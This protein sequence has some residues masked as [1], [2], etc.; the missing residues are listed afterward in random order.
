LTEIL[1]P[2]ILFIILADLSMAND[3]RIGVLINL[4]KSGSGAKDATDDLK[5]LDQ[6]AK[7]LSGGLAGL[8]D[9]AGI[10]GFAALGAAAGGVVFE[11]GKAAATAGDMRVVFDSMAKDAGESGEAMLNAMRTASAGMV[12]DAALVEA[13]NRAML[14]GV[15]DSSAEMTQLL[16]IA[17]V[18]GQAMGLS[19][20]EAFGDVVTGIG[21]LSPMILDNLGIAI[22]LQDTYDAYA[23]SLGR[24]SESLSDAEKKQALLN[25]VIANTAPLIASSVGAGQDQMASFE[26]LATS[27]SNAK[28]AFGELALTAGLPGVLQGASDEIEGL[29][30]KIRDLVISVGLLKEGKFEELFAFETGNLEAFA[31]DKMQGIGEQLAAQAEELRKAQANFAVEGDPEAQISALVKMEDAIAALGQEYN[32]LATKA[33]EPL[34]DLNLLQQGVVTAE[35]VTD[36]LNGLSEAEQRA[37]QEQEGWNALLSEAPGVVRQWAIELQGAGV[38]LDEVKDKIEANKDA[39]KT[40]QDAQNEALSG[41]FDAGGAEVDVLGLDKVLESIEPATQKIKVAIANLFQDFANGTISADELAIRLAAVSDEADN[42]ANDITTAG[43]QTEEFNDALAA[44][45]SVMAGLQAAAAAAGIPLEELIAKLG[46][47]KLALLDLMNATGGAQQRIFSSVAG[48]AD[49]VG[50]EAAFSAGQAALARYNQEQERLAED[51]ASGA[52]SNERYQFEMEVLNESLDDYAEGVQDADRESKRFAKTLEGDAKRAAK[53]AEKAFDDLKGKVSS[54]LEDAMGD[55]R[56]VN[57]DEI[58]EKLGFHEDTINENAARLADIATNGFKNQ[59]WLGEFANEV[60]DIFKALQEAGDPKAA[61]AQML[62]EFQ[63]GFR[64]EL[65]DKDLLK[66]AVKDMIAS[67]QA[68]ED[69]ANEIANELA[70]ELGTSVPDALEAARTALGSRRAG[71]ATDESGDDLGAGFAS[72]MLAG[73]ESAGT[74]AITKLSEI[75]KSEENLKLVSAAGQRNGEVFGKGFLEMLGAN[76]PQAFVDL[77]VGLVTPGVMAQQRQAASLTAAR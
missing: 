9:I 6:T 41:L 21:R 53:E 77:I 35:S 57:P 31:K 42:L 70:G 36:A 58:L 54:V 49:I 71:E 66:Q 1:L 73:V 43:Q 14:L 50:N 3:S 48:V 2:K 33:G 5:K 22:N 7:Q 74:Q 26:Q 69:L 62:K 23:D 13:A 29:T 4:V 46:D 64:P 8:A 75:L 55:V 32:Q 56:G 39:F 45:P 76:I 61:A 16:D 59:D 27:A 24:T 37:R 17:R 38:S 28:I 11:L 60:P 47:T 19:L 44:S 63:D 68:K 65:L 51:M 34:L 25:A 12:S 10:A 15:A 52:I 18:R 72:S 40:I 67:E 20:E 30:Q